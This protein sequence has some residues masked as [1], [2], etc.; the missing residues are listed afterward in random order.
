MGKHESDFKKYEIPEWYEEQYK[1][2]SGG[3]IK[4]TLNR[5]FFLRWEFARVCYQ[6]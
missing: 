5:I 6:Q 4:P 1:T 3:Y 2:F